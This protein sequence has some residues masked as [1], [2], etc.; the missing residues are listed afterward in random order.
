M[1]RR[2]VWS[3]N[4]KNRCSI[5]IYIYIYDIS[6]LR[7]NL[8]ARLGWVVKKRPGHFTP[9]KEISYQLLRRLIEHH[10]SS[11]RVRKNSPPIGIQSLDYPARSESLYRL[12]YRGQLCG[13]RKWKSGTAYEEKNSPE[14]LLLYFE[15]LCSG[16]WRRV[17]RW[18]VA[19]V[20]D[21]RGAPIFR[22]GDCLFYLKDWGVW[23]LVKYF[24]LS[25][26]QHG[27]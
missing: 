15:I 25:A 2:C 7:V 27:G 18:I 16:I 6:H 3:R 23:I 24:C 22:V 13:I 12:S 21:K 10:G 11:G 8:G 20:S 5:Y 9:E 26:K 1:L 4:I 19:T 14:F 17:T